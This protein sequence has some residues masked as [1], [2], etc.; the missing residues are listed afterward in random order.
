MEFNELMQAF[1]AKLGM[2]PIDIED[3]FAALEIDG[4]AFGFIHNPEKETLTLVADL[5]QAAIDANGE[6]GAMMLKANILFE[7]TKGSTIFQNP[8]NVSFGVQQ[9]FRIVD[10]DAERLSAEVETMANVAEEWKQLL[11][12]CSAVETE[13]KVRKSE[14]AAASK[15]VSAGDFLRV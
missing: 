8:D 12:G 13:I 5:G 6:F 7:A 14:D 4:M 2:A 10:L 1:V 15:L 11:A 3:G 9:W